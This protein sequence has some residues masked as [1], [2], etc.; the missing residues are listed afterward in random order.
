M[1]GVWSE[2]AEEGLMIPKAPK[3]KYEVFLVNF[4]YVCGAAAT[5]K[6]AKKIAKKTGFQCSIFKSTEPLCLPVTFLATH[7]TE[8]SL[9]FTL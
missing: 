6:E 8:L 5:L 7:S 4:G 9:T 2:F 1:N 3:V